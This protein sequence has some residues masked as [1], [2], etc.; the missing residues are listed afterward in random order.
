MCQETT[1]L[2]G[3]N[4]SEEADDKAVA[5]RFTK[6]KLFSSSME[7]PNMIYE[8]YPKFLFSGKGF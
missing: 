2:E 6:N 7:H 5:F 1:R 8:M 3:Q 4:S